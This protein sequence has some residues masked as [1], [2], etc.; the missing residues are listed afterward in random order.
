M[1][2]AVGLVVLWR[3]WLVTRWGILYMWRGLGKLCRARA[4]G[5]NL[6]VD[7]ECGTYF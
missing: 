2:P 3:E 1:Y 4:C 6:S 7:G 5:R